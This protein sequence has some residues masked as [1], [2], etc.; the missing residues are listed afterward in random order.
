MR[1]ILLLLCAVVVSWQY[2]I[3]EEDMKGIRGDSA[4]IVEAEAMV[5]TMGG[6]DI[7]ARIKSVHFVHEWFPWYRVDSYIENE[8]L[9]LTGPRSWVEK[10]NEIYHSIRAYSPE[11]RYWSIV[12]GEFSYADDGKLNNA[13]ERAPYSIYRM[14]RAVAIGDPR[15]EIRFGEGDIP[16]SQRL[17]F[18]GTDGIL[19]GW[20][21]LN[22]R[23]EPIVWATTQYRY[24]FG[25]MKQFGNLRVPDWAVYENGITT[26]QMIS[27]ESSNQAP[28]SSL[29]LPPL[30]YRD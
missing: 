23:K 15:Y 11:N 9:D 24:T 26:Y 10:K 18:N 30:E 14:A 28:D 13:M 27:L 21:I 16:R 5:N 20:I 17:E 3:A 7:W 25:P 6:M 2:S 12:N 1:R 4:A 22:A 19:H 29:F 8:I